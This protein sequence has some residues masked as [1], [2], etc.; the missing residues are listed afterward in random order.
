MTEQPPRKRKIPIRW[1]TLGEA[2]A[3][4]A[5]IISALGLWNSYS[6]RQQEI[7]ATHDTKPTPA[8]PLVLRASIEDKG[9]RLSL[10]PLREGLAIQGQTITFPD[11]LGVSPVETTGDSRIEAGWF[12]SALVKARSKADKPDQTAGDE[13]LAVA[14]DTAY[15]D[16]DKPM[17]DR[18]VYDIGYAVEAGGFFSGSKVLLRGVSL[19]ARG[20]GATRINALWDQRMRSAKAK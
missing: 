5:V 20:D 13:R 18:A 6:E 16:G 11:R 15:L 2:V 19:V 9:E 3:V 14:I 1:I 17:R 7:A 4:A 10:G 8:A 12:T